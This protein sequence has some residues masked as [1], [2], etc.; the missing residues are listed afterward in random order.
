MVDIFTW[1]PLYVR[2]VHTSV[3]ESLPVTCAT[4]T[5]TLTHSSCCWLKLV[6]SLRSS[7]ASSLPTS[8]SVSSML[9]SPGVATAPVGVAGDGGS[10]H[11][12]ETG[13][14][15]RGMGRGLGRRSGVAMP[16]T[17]LVA[18]G[19]RT[20]LS[21]SDSSSAIILSMRVGKSRRGLEWVRQCAL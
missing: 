6:S 17:S 9:A 16:E 12:R 3:A 15:S 18:S 20:G 1:L 2:T 5:S 14:G 19:E 11:V 13:G 7:L 21:I 4:S 10:C 8:S